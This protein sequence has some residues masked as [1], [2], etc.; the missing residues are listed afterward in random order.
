[1]KKVKPKLWHHYRDTPFEVM[2]VILFSALAFGGTGAALAHE[3]A[4]KESKLHA[5]QI[6]AHQQPSTP[7]QSTKTA[8]VHRG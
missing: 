2:S 8:P 6:A 4:V 5:A 7:P 3:S 1:M